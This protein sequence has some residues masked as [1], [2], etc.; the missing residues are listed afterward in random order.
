M[1]RSLGEK[2]PR[3]SERD[4]KG[5]QAAS[6]VS[7]AGPLLIKGGR[8]IDPAG[9]VDEVQDLLI[10]EGLIKEVS[11]S[12]ASKGAA[13]IDATGK[14][15]APG[16]VDM[17]AHLREP[18]REDEETIESGT[19]AAVKGGFTAVCCMPNT[20]PPIDDQGT[21]RFILERSRRF[22]KCHVFPVGTV[23]KGRKGEE[24]SEIG[25]LVEAGCVAISDDGS[26]VMNGEIMRRALEYSKQFSIPVISH[27]ED[28]NLTRDFQMN[29][30][31][32]STKLGMRGYPPVA[33]EVMVA[34]DIS[35]CAYT[36]GRLHIAHISTKG[37]V[38]LVR[39][40]KSAGIDVTCEVTPHHLSLTDDLISSFDTALKTNPPLRTK[41]DVDALA[42]GVADG[43]I[44][45]IAT[46]HAPH[47]FFEKEVEFA[48]A[49]FGMVGL[50]TAVGVVLTFLV[51]KKRIP[52]GRMVSCMSSNPARILN[53]DM[54]TLKAG[55]RGNVV[56][57]DT[58]ARWTVKADS[59][60]S[61]SRN[62]PYVGSELEGLIW[63]TVVDGGIVFR[64]GRVVD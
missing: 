4:P 56:I 8:V 55:A 14:I 57:V 37:S 13:T 33:E 40:A 35:L 29:E 62:S 10:E 38:E 18:G 61:R 44:D 27:C 64:D 2:K 47:A 11:K 3:D 36:G 45:A 58:N 50:E 48:A 34:R 41:E 16:F 5:L 42:D 20:E 9:G 31:F 52:I 6:T 26:S 30:G 23:T 12:I 7:G 19:R 17:H 53:L 22:G 25:D 46:D 54:G 28:A 59:F 39:Q 60:E 63:M 21:V 15:V 24:I 43:T 49:P 51:K 1:R 32:M